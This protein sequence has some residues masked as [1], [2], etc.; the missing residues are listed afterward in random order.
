MTACVCNCPCLC[1]SYAT[2]ARICSG[3]VVIA[4]ASSVR[5][6]VGRL[7]RLLSGVAVP[8]MPDAGLHSTRHIQSVCVVLLVISTDASFRLKHPGVQD[9]SDGSDR[10]SYRLMENYTLPVTHVTGCIAYLTPF[11]CGQYMHHH[12]NP[13]VTLFP[14]AAVMLKPFTQRLAI[15]MPFFSR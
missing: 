9:S 11:L 4:R 14:W 12:N 5:M 8:A 3:F 13:C 7:S 6:V 10:T 1:L 2:V 15:F